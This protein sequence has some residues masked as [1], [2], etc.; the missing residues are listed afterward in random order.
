M[1]YITNVG[2]QSKKIFAETDHIFQY[3]NITSVR[4]ECQAQ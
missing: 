3:S 2:I 4:I 1:L